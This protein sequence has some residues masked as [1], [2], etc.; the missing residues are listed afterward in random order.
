M[1]KSIISFLVMAMVI[2]FGNASVSFGGTVDDLKN[3]CAD[4]WPGDYQMQEHCIKTQV[5]ALFVF[6]NQYSKPSME[7]YK[8]SN[9]PKDIKMNDPRIPIEF[10]IVVMCAEEWKI[11]HAWGHDYQMVVHCCKTQFNA[12]KRIGKIK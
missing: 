9:L 12:A 11:P 5:N 10:K 1:R 3:Y 8:A 2:M 7:K 4:E 6:V